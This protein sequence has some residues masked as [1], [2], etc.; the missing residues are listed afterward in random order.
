MKSIRFV[1]PIITAFF[2][3]MAMPV[4]PSFSEEAKPDPGTKKILVVYFSHTGNTREIANQI[5]KQVGGDIFEI[6]SVD[7][8]PADYDTCV[9]QAKEELASGYKPALKTQVKNIA[10]YDVIFIGY[11]N[12][13][14][15]FPA[16]VRTFLSENDL[17][18]KTIVPFCTHGGSGLG[19]SVT[20][21]SELCP[22]STLLEGIAIYGTQVKTAQ[23]EVSAWLKRIKVKE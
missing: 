12:W 6:Q 9:Q 8:Y 17:S 1:L 21:L 16:P 15:T 11:P 2:V 4:Q 23:A 10:S 5:H 19:R 13:W 7:P 22:R 14:G 3:L 18:G 20:D